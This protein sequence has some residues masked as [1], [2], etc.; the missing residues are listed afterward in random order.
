MEA[1]SSELATIQRQQQLDALVAKSKA[2]TGR[3]SC[4]QSIPLIAL[5]LSIVGIVAINFHAAENIM[6][7]EIENMNHAM[8]LP[9]R[10]WLEPLPA[11]TIAETQNLSSTVPVSARAVSKSTPIA[12]RSNDSS[13]AALERR[14]IADT[15]SL[16]TA[17]SVHL[18]DKTRNLRPSAAAVSHV[19]PR[20]V[21]SGPSGSNATAPVVAATVSTSS[22]ASTISSPATSALASS[23]SDSTIP[24]VYGANPAPLIAGYGSCAHFRVANA[25]RRVVLGPAGLFNTGTNYLEALLRMN[26]K[27]SNGKPGSIWQVPWGKHNPVEWRGSHYAPSG[28]GQNISL[29]M[30]VMMIKD[31]LTWMK[32]MCRKPYA[33]K[34]KKL[35]H[36]PSPVRDT[37]TVVSFQRDRKLAYKSLLDLWG[38]WNRAYIEMKVPHLIVRYEDVL[39]NPV[40]TVGKICACTGGVMSGSFKNLSKQAKSGKGHGDGGSDRAKALTLY[41]DPVKRVEGYSDED[42][43]YIRN[44]W[45]TGLIRY[46]QY[47]HG[48][49]DDLDPKAKKGV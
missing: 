1:S 12:T 30:P 14:P 23:S 48:L 37:S 35:E 39:F 45:D 40:E 19:V 33:A 38:Q 16:P 34:F 28:K 42:L 15:N 18:P 9:Q 5:A 25:N 49:M 21:S 11:A 7:A 36:C 2:S 46:F 31:P 6:K 4:S 22:S 3:G 41:G 44:N 43:Q 32:S 10:H 24:A 8:H 17:P 13:W 20:V 26:C 29:V 47:Y 27:N